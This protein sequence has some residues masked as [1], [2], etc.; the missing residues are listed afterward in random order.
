[1]RDSNTKRFWLAGAAALALVLGYFLPRHGVGAPVAVAVAP[2]P[3]A[4]VLTQLLAGD[5]TAG[6]SQ[7]TP[8]PQ[9]ARIA[10]YVCGA[11]R[12][13]GVYE[14]GPNRRV[15]DGIARAG[16]ALPDADVEQLN[17]AEPLSDA[18]KIDV[19]KKGERVV[20]PVEDSLSYAGSNHDHRRSGHHGGRSSHKLQPGQTLNLNTA[21]EPELTSLPGVGP[22]LARRIVE[23]RTAN[24]P[25]HSVDDLQNVSGIGASKFDRIAPF[26]RL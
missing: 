23:Y 20:A 12:R 17:L 9:L 26:V 10:V 3:E 24:G 13:P 15:A 5:S 8:S 11:V 22:G 14:F 1:M 19:P 2:T 4:T 25:F 21:G 7:V 16:G 18:M 6:S